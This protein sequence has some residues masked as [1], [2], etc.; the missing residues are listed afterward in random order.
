MTEPNRTLPTPAAILE[1]WLPLK[2]VIGITS[3]RNAADYE[4]IMGVIEV[5]LKEVGD[6]EDHPL[7]DVL[8][9]LSNRVQAYEA[10]IAPIPDS[11]PAEVLAFLMEQHG[12]VQEDLKDCAPQSRISD[13]LSGKNTAS[14]AIA[15]KLGARFGVGAGL[16]I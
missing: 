4:R 14:K 10:E 9:F 1:A 13:I 7:A 5:L 16:F 3:V 12:L 2:E 6:N 11:S 15:K 8:D